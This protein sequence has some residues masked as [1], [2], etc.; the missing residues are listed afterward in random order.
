VLVGKM[1]VNGPKNNLR[2]ERERHMVNQDLF[3]YYFI[4]TLGVLFVIYALI[5]IITMYMK[6][7]FTMSRMGKIIGIMILAA[8]LLF[9][10]LPSLKYVALK[11]YVVIKGKCVVDIDSSGRTT[12]A[13]IRMLG[14][15]EYFSFREIPSLDAYGKAIP[16]YCEVTMT[17]DHM[18]EISYKIYHE[19]K[20]ELMAESN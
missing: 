6:K 13:A 20:G 4:L 10:T 5:H 17:K 15:G 11:D 16:Y 19:E 12:L 8:L 3:I 14:S 7:D 2:K 1:S 9:T 18:L